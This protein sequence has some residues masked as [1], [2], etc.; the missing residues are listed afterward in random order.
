MST[1]LRTVTLTFTDTPD[2][3]VKVVSDPSFET[4]CQMEIS[5][6]GL[7]SANGYALLAINAIRKAAKSKDIDQ[8]VF[9]PRIGK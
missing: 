4:M 7:S 8:K 3:K 2:G 6:H 9:I 5:G 1:L